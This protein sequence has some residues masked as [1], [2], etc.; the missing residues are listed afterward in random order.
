MCPQI[1]TTVSGT[2]D[3]CRELKILNSYELVCV[4]QVPFSS[5]CRERETKT[6]EANVKLRTLQ[7]NS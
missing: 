7:E 6:E 5:D 1:K 2:Y 4:K 3:S